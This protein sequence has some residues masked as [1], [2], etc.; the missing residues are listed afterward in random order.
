MNIYAE[1]GTKVKYIGASDSQVRWGSNDDPRNC[2]IEGQLYTIDHTE[3]HSYHTKIYLKEFPDL[4]FNSCSFND[5][6]DLPDQLEL[7]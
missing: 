3:V 1:E 5:E 6:T 7:F 4:K 2:L